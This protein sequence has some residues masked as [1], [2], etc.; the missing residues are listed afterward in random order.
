MISRWFAGRD[1]RCFNEIDIKDMPLGGRE[2]ASLRG[3]RCE[4][5]PLEIGSFEKS[6]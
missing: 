1:S 5:A 2:N 4:L 3:F 6:R